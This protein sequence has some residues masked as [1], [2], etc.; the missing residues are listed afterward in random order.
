MKKDIRKTNFT[1]LFQSIIILLTDMFMIWYGFDAIVAPIFN[2]SQISVVQAIG[3]STFINVIKN[4]VHSKEENE[5][6]IGP[7]QIVTYVFVDFVYFLIMF[8]I[9]FFI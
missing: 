4:T 3:L 5:Q 7:A 9:S 6:F 8:T 1:P 2:L